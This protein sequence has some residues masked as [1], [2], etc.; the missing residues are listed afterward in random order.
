MHPRC[1]RGRVVKQTKNVLFI[2]TDNIF[3]GTYIY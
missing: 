2:I 1:K 3:Q